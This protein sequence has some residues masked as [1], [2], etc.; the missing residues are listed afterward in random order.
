MTHKFFVVDPVSVI[1]KS[2]NFAQSEHCI[3]LLG[4]SVGLI[5]PVPWILFPQFEQVGLF[6]PLGFMILTPMYPAPQL[7]C[8]DRSLHQRRFPRYPA[9]YI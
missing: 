3:R 1:D 6:C 8:Y 2:H 9:L 7:L 5:T 4:S